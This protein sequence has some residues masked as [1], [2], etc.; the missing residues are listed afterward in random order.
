MYIVANHLTGVIALVARAIYNRGHYRAY[1]RGQCAVYVV[2][3]GSC[4]THAIPVGS[5]DI[6]YGKTL[7]KVV[8]MCM[9]ISWLLVLLTLLRTIHLHQLHGQI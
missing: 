2:L 8:E 3:A 4:A 5:N 9:M 6:L 1:V 7:T